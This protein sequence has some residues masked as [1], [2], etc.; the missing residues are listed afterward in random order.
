M[1]TLR[2]VHI[3]GVGSELLH[4]RALTSALS[5]THT[6][7]AGMSICLNSSIY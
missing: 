6:L 7:V 4:G 2:I 1:L 3:S 5:E